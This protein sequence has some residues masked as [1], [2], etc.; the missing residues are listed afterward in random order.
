MGKT[1]A[2]AL[3]HNNSVSYFKLSCTVIK[4]YVN[5][6]NTAYVDNIY[7][8]IHTFYICSDHFK[9]NCFERDLKVSAFIFGLYNIFKFIF[10]LLYS[11]ILSTTLIYPQYSQSFLKFSC[12][13]TFKTP[14]CLHFFRR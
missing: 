1:C 8:M 2:D 11:S 13:C 14:K 4:I 10:F 9:P 7:Q 3:C 12:F 5:V 6:G